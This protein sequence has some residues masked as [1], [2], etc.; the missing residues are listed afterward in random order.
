MAS[1]VFIVPILF[2]AT[3]GAVA[4]AL[5]GYALPAL[6]ASSPSLAW[7]NGAAFTTLLKMTLLILAW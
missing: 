3:I 1:L 7:A 4:V 5:F 2:F 6:A